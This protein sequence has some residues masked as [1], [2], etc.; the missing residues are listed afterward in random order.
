MKRVIDY[1]YGYR[2]GIIVLCFRSRKMDRIAVTH[3][4]VDNYLDEIESPY[5][6]KKLH[7]TVSLDKRLGLLSEYFEHKQKL[8]KSNK[9]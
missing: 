7:E 5:N 2:N 4:E 6:F 3:T 1:R 8:T 9:K